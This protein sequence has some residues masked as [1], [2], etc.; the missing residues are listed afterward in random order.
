MRSVAQDWWA[1]SSLSPW[2]QVSCG[3]GPSAELVCSPSI[4]RAA[5]PQLRSS[6]GGPPIAQRYLR[7]CDATRPTRHQDPS[8][9]PETGSTASKCSQIVTGGK[10]VLQGKHSNG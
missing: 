10:I 2:R 4:R 3:S 8:S 7:R 9:C 5:L 6:P 1:I